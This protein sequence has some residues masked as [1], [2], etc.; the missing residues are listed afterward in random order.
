MASSSFYSGTGVTP[1]NPNV[2]AVPPS[3]S[4]LIE[5][6]EP[7]NINAIESSVANAKASEDAAEASAVSAASSA[8]ISLSGVPGIQGPVGP[9]GA[10][11]TIVGP[12]GIQG[13]AGTDASV[14]ASTVSAV[15]ALMDSEVTNL[16]QVKAFDQTDYA[17]AAQG[18]QA[19][20]A[21]GWG[22]HAAAGY[23][24]AAAAESNALALAIAL[25]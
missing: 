25:G 17:T 16:A 21:Y 14:T 18:T 1:D 23:T 12:Q 4:P 19:N 9:A 5:P 7:L 6:V 3:N 11:S 10:D 22:D 13:I 20:T 24:T 2:E 8:A 15:G